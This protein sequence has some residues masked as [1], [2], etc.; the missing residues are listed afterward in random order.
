MTPETILPGALKT[1][2]EHRRD[3]C[4]VG[5][6]MH[7]RGYVAATDGNLSVRLDGDTILCTPTCMSKGMMAPEDLERLGAERLGTETHTVD[8]GLGQDVGLLGV[9]RAGIRLDGPLAPGMET[10]PS[11]DDDGQPS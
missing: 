9:D 10:Q 4:A 2:D 3:I 1:E 11:L 8:T 7:E 5:R 6:M